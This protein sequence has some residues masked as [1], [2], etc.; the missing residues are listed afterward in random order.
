MAVRLTISISPAVAGEFHPL[1]ATG[2]MHSC[3]PYN[4]YG[5][6]GLPTHDP[7]AGVSVPLGGIQDPPSG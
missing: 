6:V 3:T 2:E 5:R 4:Q 7:G 1:K